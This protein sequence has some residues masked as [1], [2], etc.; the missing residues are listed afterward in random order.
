MNSEQSLIPYSR[1]IKSIKLTDGNGRLLKELDHKSIIAK[2][3]II[4]P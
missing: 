4:F 1:N 3:W 2:F